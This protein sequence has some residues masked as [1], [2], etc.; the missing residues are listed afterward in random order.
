MLL[1]PEL[2]LSWLISYAVNLTKM[3]SDQKLASLNQYFVGSTA[4]KKIK[5]NAT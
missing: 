4:F 5:K 1:Q 3:A 2:T